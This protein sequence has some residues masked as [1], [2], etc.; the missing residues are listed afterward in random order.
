MK[1]VFL[2]MALLCA[3]CSAEPSSTLSSR[4]LRPEVSERGIN[5]GKDGLDE[6]VGKV[7]TRSDA[8]CRIV[9]AGVRLCM[10]NHGAEAWVYTLDNHP[11]HGAALFR[12]LIDRDGRIVFEERG[13]FAGEEAAARAFFDEA[14]E[15][16]PILT[17][18]SEG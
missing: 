10:I 2:V 15:I 13:W 8:A 1:R 18:E 16:M 9:T 14:A 5:V 3:G 17:F 7:A 6:L 11:A 12:G 4:D